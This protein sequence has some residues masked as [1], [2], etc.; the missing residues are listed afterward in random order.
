MEIQPVEVDAHGERHMARRRP[1][2][3]EKRGL[4]RSFAEPGEPPVK[5]EQKPPE[6][7]HPRQYPDLAE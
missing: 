6:L 1:A 7:G 2:E 3:G 4:S 5:A